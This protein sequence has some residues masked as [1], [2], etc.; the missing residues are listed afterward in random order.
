VAVSLVLTMPVWRHPTTDYIGFPSDPMMFMGFLGWYPFAISHGLNPLHDGYV[1]LPGGSN[2]MWAT[3]V[4]LL[5]LVLWPIT[6]AFNV[7]ASWNVGVLG[8]LVLNGYCTFLWV[9]RHVRHESAAWLG[10]LI[11]VVGPFSLFRAQGHLNL[12]AFFPVPLVIVELEKLLGHETTARAAGWKIG[13]LMAVELL[14][15]EDIVSMSAVAFG[16]GLVI[17]AVLQRR[18]LVRQA[19][20][21]VSSLA[22]SIPAFLLITGAPLAY[23]FF[24]PGRIVGLLHPPDIFVTDLVN[25]VVP[26]YFEALNP[27]FAAHLANHW[28]AGFGESESYIGVP[29]LLV[30]IFVAVRWRREA[31]VRAV[32]LGT[33]AILIWSLGSYLHFDGVTEQV[34]LPGRLLSALP[35][36]DNLLPV[37]FDL[38]TEF[39]LAAL[40]AVF[41]D[42]IVLNRTLGRERRFGGSVLF[43]LV[44]VTLAPRAPLT[45]YE[46][47]IP[48]YFSPA[49]GAASLRQGTV[50]LVVPYGDGDNSEEPML[51]QATSGFRFRMVAGDMETA[52]RDGT[53]M[54]GRT[55]WGTGTPMDC[56]F[57][58]LQNGES[59]SS[60][61]AHPVT[62]VRSA[63]DKL[64]VSMIIMG[65]MDYGDNP[66]LAPP[67]SAFLSKVAGGKP[68]A[69]EGALLWNYH[70]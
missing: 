28:S 68:R 56:I 13:V 60:C 23:Q 69:D 52:G 3:T 29:L 41:V 24:G 18:G 45:V 58:Y 67:V 19:R 38:F 48:K 36:F 66:A 32:G 62:A 50:A 17:F 42:R 25:V 51:W 33:L 12:L 10:A 30:S 31:W 4:P 16:T 53:P 63:L 11:L 54:E 1:N 55:L 44:C 22:T 47:Q 15:S 65:P 9:R 49:G 14:C 5:S 6:A 70:P 2:M 37:R 34:P 35:V 20:L 46:P 59:I 57:Q 61:T 8:L 43:L 7:I 21:L 26:G 64:R 40:A 27:S 39:G